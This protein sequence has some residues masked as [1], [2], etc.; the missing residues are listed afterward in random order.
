MIIAIITVTNATVVL[1]DDGDIVIDAN[2]PSVTCGAIVLLTMILMMVML[3]LML[4]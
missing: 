3:L 1:D 4:L 2:V